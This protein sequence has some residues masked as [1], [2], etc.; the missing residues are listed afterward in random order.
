MAL[1]ASISGLDRSPV[2][3]AVEVDILVSILT[4]PTISFEQPEES[5]SDGEADLF[6]L[7]SSAIMLQQVLDHRHQ[8]E[9]TPA[10]SH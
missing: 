5:A 10:I 8:S 4:K 7:A 2:V 6:T 1:E 3:F 9:H